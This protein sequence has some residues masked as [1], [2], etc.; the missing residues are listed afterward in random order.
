MPRLIN[1]RL[2]RADISAHLAKEC[3]KSAVQEWCTTAVRIIFITLQTL[4]FEV[5]DAETYFAR[6]VARKVA[7]HA[8]EKWYYRAFCNVEQSIV[9]EQQDENL[10]LVKQMP[11]W[12]KRKGKKHGY[13]MIVTPANLEPRPIILQL[14]YNCASPSFH[15]TGGITNR[16]LQQQICVHLELTSGFEIRIRKYRP[17]LRHQVKNFWIPESSALPCNDR[18]CRHLLGT[19]LLIWAY[20][21]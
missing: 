1:Q 9:R 13:I 15:P 5:V 20:R 21:R 11:D 3:A 4:P 7:M 14:D 16:L 2:D 18:Q 6:T 10:L 8:L 19:T 17:W 12:Q